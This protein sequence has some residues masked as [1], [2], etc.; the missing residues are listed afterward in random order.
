MPSKPVENWKELVDSLN[1]LMEG[2]SHDSFG[3]S[4]SE[5]RESYMLQMIYFGSIKPQYFDGYFDN[6]PFSFMALRRF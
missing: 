4:I 5:L 6:V 2:R 3:R 1:Y